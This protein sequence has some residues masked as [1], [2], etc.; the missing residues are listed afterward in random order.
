MSPIAQKELRRK[1]KKFVEEEVEDD[2]WWWIVN[3][4]IWASFLCFAVFGLLVRLAVS[5]HPYSGAANPPKYGDFEA[6]RHW[7]EITLN[8]PIKDWYTN[9]T[10]NDLSYWGLDYPPL[11]AY[12]SYFHG[13]FLRFFHPDS[14]S[15]FTSRGH[16]SY[17]GKLLMRWTVLSSDALVFFPSVLYFVFVYHTGRKSSRKTEIAWHIAMVL[18]NPCLIL[19]DH[20]H[21]QYNCISLGLTVG[22]VAAILSNSDLIACFL[23]SLALNH[24]QMSAY[25]APAFFSHL[26]GK[27]LKRSNPLLEVLKLGFVVVGTFSLIWWPYIHSMEAFLQVLSRLAPFERGLYEDYVANFWCTTSV[28]IK[29]KKLFTTPTLKLLSFGATISTCLP[30]MIQQIWAPSKRGFL[31]GLLNSAFSFYLF[32]FQVHEKSILLPLL[33]A[34]LLAIEEPF[35]YNWITLNALFSMFPL[36]VRDKLVIPYI[37]LLGLF[38]LL[39]YASPNQIRGTKETKTL[40]SSLKALF[41]VC[42]LIF[43]IV[44]LTLPAPNR[45]PYLFEALVML[46]CFSQFVSLAFYTN[47]QQ[48][49][50][51]KHSVL[52]DKE[53]KLL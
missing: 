9:S 21:F 46:L 32:S 50:L 41:L 39:Y 3:N 34:S 51:L 26:L 19:I 11:T 52:V 27:C 43:H 44:Y 1:T 31:Y 8:L 22:A 38:S 47:A 30:S 12:Q 7:M 5:V 20:G 17:L 13:L 36:L 42:A 35:L 24:K 16:E 18:L 6:Q 14:V 29:W 23:F 48:W 33:P 28:V 4:G 49:M 37:A 53:K 25:F 15:L 2:G 40:E 10:S 45:Y